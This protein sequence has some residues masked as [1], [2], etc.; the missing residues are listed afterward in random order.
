MRGRKN[1]YTYDVHTYCSNSCCCIIILQWHIY[2]IHFICSD[3]IT[4]TWPHFH[5]QLKWWTQNLREE[6]LSKTTQLKWLRYLSLL[7]FR[8]L[9][10]TT[11]LCNNMA[12]LSLCQCF[13]LARK[14]C[15][16]MHIIATPL[17][18]SFLREKGYTYLCDHAYVYTPPFVLV[19]RLLFTVLPLCQ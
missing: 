19:H 9:T 3:P 7:V 12:C 8:G 17:F 13:V 15:N 11:C 4:R 10:T 2:L 14:G 16:N 6:M 18:C 5:R 1:L